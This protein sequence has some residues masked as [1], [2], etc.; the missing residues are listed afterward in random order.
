VP[1]IPPIMEINRLIKTQL[2]ADLSNL[3]KVVMLYGPRQAGKT[4]LS[5]QV[6][7]EMDLK[8]L[9]VNAD[10][11]KYLEVLSSRD[12]GK[13]RSLVAGYELLFIDEGQRI[14][15]IGINLKILHDELP[16][17]KILVTGSSS[18]LLSGRVS[19]SL[20]G[21][22]KIYTLL[23]VSMQ[24]L[25]GI[26]NA[27]ELNDQ[28]EDRLIFGSYPE[29]INI[30]NSSAREEYL[31]DISSSFIF[32]DILE[33]EMIKYPLKIRDLLRLLAYQTGSQVSIHELGNKLG[34]NRDTVERYLFLLEQSFVIFKLPAF[35]HN[36]RKEISK[37]QKYYFYDTGIRNILIGNMKPLSER[38]DTG[39]LWE[40]FII[41]ERR[42]YL[43]YNQKNANGYFWRTYAGTEIDY[44]EER[45]TD[46]FAYEIK[47][48]RSKKRIPVSWSEGYG[49]NYQI[50]NRENYL[51]FI[52]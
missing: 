8:T 40:N 5:K 28:L 43:L 41:A 14:P 15:E 31:H 1:L 50:I 45:M 29:V 52:F 32:K 46:F 35:S 37:S 48:G 51:D 20:A 13:L 4:T 24:E 39:A 12:L 16:E 26:N 44:V 38:N 10:Q 3:G 23:P 19:E 22:K 11:S 21:R 33:L 34:L 27:F 9:M 47:S 36:P 49:S 42:K 30:V 6:I 7:Q 17:L 25:G 2:I 18:F